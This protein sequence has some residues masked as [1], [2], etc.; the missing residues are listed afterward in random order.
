M[1]AI[2]LGALA[3]LGSVRPPK[4]AGGTLARRHIVSV[5]LA[6][7]SCHILH[8]SLPATAIPPLEMVMQAQVD[9]PPPQVLYTPPAVKGTSTPEA[10]AL[11]KH[12]KEKGAKMYG[13]YWC[14]H[15]FNQKLAFG[16]GGAR[17]LNYVECAADGYQ[18]QRATC[19][20]KQV[21]GYP[22]WEIDGEYYRGEKSLEELMVISGFKL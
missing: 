14:S 12:L 11:A 8:T 7:A 18:S 5:A 6:A 19:Q 16:A 21:A 3:L 10:L 13:A 2:L 15:C 20:E 1:V 9:S 4:M 22:T 17:M